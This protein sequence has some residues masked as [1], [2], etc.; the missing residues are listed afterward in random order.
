MK[1][2]KH[3]KIDINVNVQKWHYNILFV[4]GILP[5]ECV[6]GIESKMK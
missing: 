4:V 1:K 2:E 6:Q 5:A 3:L